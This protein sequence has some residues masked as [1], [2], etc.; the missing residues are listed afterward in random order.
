MPDG[1]KPRSWFNVEV[2]GNETGLNRFNHCG[3]VVLWGLLHVPER[4]TAAQI[5]AAEDSLHTDVSTK[6]VREVHLTEKHHRVLQ[7]LSRGRMRDPAEGEPEA[8]AAMEALV[9]DGDGSLGTV[10]R[11][12]LPGVQWYQQLGPG[13]VRGKAVLI[14]D[15]LVRYLAELPAETVDVALCVAKEASKITE[16]EEMVPKTWRRAR[17][18]ALTTAKE[19]RVEG[20]R[21]IRKSLCP[22]P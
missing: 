8:A 5:A 22:I 18:L 1:V 6:R 15:A 21:L 19:W 9:I 3:L 7:A 4:A 14:A 2:H 13:V 10:M 12:A 11:E 16:G 20:H 17:D